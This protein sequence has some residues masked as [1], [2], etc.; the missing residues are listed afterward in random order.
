MYEYAARLVRVVDGDTWIL[1]IDLGCS[2]WLHSQRIR[3]AR[4]NAPEMSTDAGKAAK[5]YA[6]SWFAENAPDNRVVLRTEK[7]RNDNYGR[8]LGTVSSQGRVLNTD[9]VQSGNAT[10]Y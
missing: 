8:L 6:E 1:D 2:V 9:L 3:G 5:T 7:D 10:V 4:I